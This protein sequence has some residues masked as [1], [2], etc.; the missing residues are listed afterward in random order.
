MKRITV[1]YILLVLS[2]TWFA[3]EYHRDTVRELKI[4]DRWA[5]NN[6]EWR[7]TAEINKQTEMYYCWEKVMLRLIEVD[8]LEAL[9]T[10]HVRAI[11]DSCYSDP[12]GTIKLVS[13]IRQEAGLE[14]LVRSVLD[15]LPTETEVSE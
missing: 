7:V 5:L 3:V 6:S 9:D 15:H 14:F 1:L 4:G 10:E 2:L 11:N 13:E 12:K 8:K